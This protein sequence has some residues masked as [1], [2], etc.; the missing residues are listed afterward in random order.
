ME[1]PRIRH[2]Q[3]DIEIASSLSLAHISGLISPSAELLLLRL[4]LD[5]ARLSLSSLHWQL[6]SNLERRSCSYINVT[7]NFRNRDSKSFGSNLKSGSVQCPVLQRISN[8]SA[9][10]A[11]LLECWS[12]SFEPTHPLR[13]SRFFCFWIFF[14]LILH[15]CYLRCEMS[16]DQ[17]TRGSSAS[18]LTPTPVQPLHSSRRAAVTYARRNKEATR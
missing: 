6:R 8:H 11:S 15:E 14:F 16:T 9:A 12:V 18:C 5:R 7:Q 13:E 3:I 10:L 2:T 1:Y 17:S 4:R